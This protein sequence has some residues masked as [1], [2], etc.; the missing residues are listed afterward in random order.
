MTEFARCVTHYAQLAMQPG[1]FAYCQ[2]AVSALESD[3]SHNGLFSGLRAAVG[4]A[5]KLAG[6]RPAPHE[7]QELWIEKKHQGV[8]E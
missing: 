2:S 6:Y 4:A 8:T 5:I 1:F 7:L 3:K